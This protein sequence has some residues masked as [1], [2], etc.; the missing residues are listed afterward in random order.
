MGVMINGYVHCGTNRVTADVDAT[1]WESVEKTPKW[2]PAGSAVYATRALPVRQQARQLGAKDSAVDMFV[3]EA[4]F[5]TV[6][7]VNFDASRIREMLK[8]AGEVKK[9]AQAMY[10][11]AAARA[12]LTPEKPE[13]PAQYTP[14]DTVEGLL[15]QASSIGV[16]PTRKA[17][18]DD[19]AGL[20]ELL[21]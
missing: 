6:T 18:G 5:T 13:G 2:R 10:E 9:T 16:M 1:N 12:G 17:L 15:E 7:N 20:L 19:L 14:A 3:V 21:T 11:Q 4:L 8:K